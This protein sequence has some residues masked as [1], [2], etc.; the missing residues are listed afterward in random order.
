M[1]LKGCPPERFLEYKRKLQGDGSASA[2]HLWRILKWSSVASGTFHTFPLEN[3]MFHGTSKDFEFLMPYSHTRWSRD[4]REIW[5]KGRGIFAAEDPRVAL[6]YTGAHK[7]ARP[8]SITRGIDLINLTLPNQPISYSLRGGNSVED[9]LDQ[10]Y[11]NSDGSDGAFGYIHV[12]DRLK[13]K[14]EPG[15]GQMEL[16]CRGNNAIVGRIVV[17]RRRALDDF[18]GCGDVIVKWRPNKSQETRSVS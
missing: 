14:R 5:W 15:L 9:A 11:G 17:H 1:D 12:L 2:A 3:L 6:F 18:L 13:G 7:M 4:R 8:K 16:V 10:L